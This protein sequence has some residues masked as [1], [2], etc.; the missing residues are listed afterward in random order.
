MR[1]RETGGRNYGIDLLRILAMFFVVLLHSLDGTKVLFPDN[2]ELCNTNLYRVLW[3]LEIIA[4]GAVDTFALISGYVGYREKPKTYKISSI[5][6]L[7]LQVVLYSIIITV[8]THFISPSIATKTDLFVQAT[9]LMH[10]NY[11][12]LNAYVGLFF[13]MPIL[14]TAIRK[15]SKKSLKRITFAILAVCCIGSQLMQ[16]NFNL[17][18]GYSVIWL[19]VLYITGAT[20]KKCDIGKKL[21]PFMCLIIIFSLNLI[22]WLLYLLRKIFIVGDITISTTA[23]VG[24]L[25]PTVVLASIFYIICFSKLKFPNFMIK[26]IKFGAPGAFAAYILNTNHF[27]Y[28]YGRFWQ[29]PQVGVIP[30]WQIIILTVSFSLAFLIASILIDKIRQELFVKLRINNALQVLDHKIKSITK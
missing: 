10:K 22:T 20:I 24:Y 8:I 11:W 23:L 5:L 27:F 3:L 30:S 15:L 7:W 21:K 26:I 6:S 9:P 16:M 13:F 25:S 17:N 28:D 18:E 29:A 14:D 12:Y 4:Y 2:L 19:I 1:N